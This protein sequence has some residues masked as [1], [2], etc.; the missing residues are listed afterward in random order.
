MAKK[1]KKTKKKET[2]IFWR[3][4]ISLVG[5]ALIVIAVSNLLLYFFGEH[6]AVSI[7]TRRYGGADDGKPADKR[8]EWYIDYTFT[9]KEGETHS[10]HTTRRGSDMSVDVSDT[11][12]YYF[13][14][15]PFINA[16]ENEAKPG[17]SQLIF[18]VLGVFLFYIMNRKQVK[19]KPVK[20]KN[21]SELTDYD[22]SV[23]ESFHG[24]N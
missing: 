23:E 12:V 17:V 18:V 2:S 3:I 8:Y 10:G 13:T 16:L 11:C 24:D 9:D 22:D 7:T 1:K 19:R 15:A 6:A 4:V 14:F 5:I 21:P 20:I